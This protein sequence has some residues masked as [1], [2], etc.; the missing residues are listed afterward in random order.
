MTFDDLY[1]TYYNRV[2]YAAF[3]VTKDPLNAE[4]ILQETF[5]K[6]Y[7]RL[8]EV[9]DPNKIGSWLTTIARRKAIDFLRKEKRAVCLSLD[10]Q[11]LT[12]DQAVSD[13]EKT[14]LERD[15]EQGLTRQILELPTKL[16]EAFQLSYLHGLKEKEIARKLGIS[17]SAVKS[18]LFRAR[19]TLRASYAN[20]SENS[21]A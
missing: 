9:E 8:G 21:I 5:L 13:V 12:L 20:V 3:A 18:R 11:L 16:K 19:H 17:Q 1:Q 14:C 15:A 10:E 2:Y 6:A 4:D 7:D